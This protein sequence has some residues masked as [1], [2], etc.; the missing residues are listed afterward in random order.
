MQRFKKIALALVAA[1]AIMISL[2]GVASAADH[3]APG[4][5]DDNNCRG[6]TAA[7]MAQRFHNPVDDS[8]GIGND[9]EHIGLSVH[10]LHELRIRARCG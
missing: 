6:Q 3:S 10:D 8:P 1:L 4:D 2:A 7:F 5:P 9:A